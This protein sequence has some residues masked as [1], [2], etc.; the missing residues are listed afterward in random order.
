M[1]VT[2]LVTE[3]ER[4]D[5]VPS[6]KTTQKREKDE[7]MRDINLIVRSCC[8][9]LDAIGIVYGNIVAVSVNTR[10][11]SRWGQCKRIN[12]CYEINISSRLMSEDVALVHLED[13]VMHEILHTCEGCMNH[14]ATWK[15]LA[16]KVNRAYGY[17]IKRATSADEKGIV[18]PVQTVPVIRYKFA[19][20]GCGGIIQRERAS[21]FTKYPERFRCGI[22]NGRFQR[23]I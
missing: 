9:K 22:C 5:D 20:V 11:K 21:K 18:D 12:G 8:K 17:N 2:W 16:D 1:M 3:T 6:W 4:R 23:I 15:N 10:A 13:T 14:G 19:C 7:S